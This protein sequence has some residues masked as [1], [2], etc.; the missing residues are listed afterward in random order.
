MGREQTCLFRWSQCLDKVTHK[1]IK[2]FLQFQHK[3][4]YTD[5]KDAKTID[6]VETKCH[7]ICSWW[8]SF[9][10]VIKE[11]IIRLFEW[12]GFWNFRYMQW[13]SHMILVSA[14]SLC[15]SDVIL[16]FN[17]HDFWDLDFIC[18]GV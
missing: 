14:S 4:L 18:V 5:S 16:I 12:L 17:I 10:V 13:S 15:I 6:E 1:Y 8:L 2:T 7:I 11:G 9:K 3:Q